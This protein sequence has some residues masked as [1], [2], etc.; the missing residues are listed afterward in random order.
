M[1]LKALEFANKVGTPAADDFDYQK[2]RLRS[3]FAANFT[4]TFRGFF[5]L[6]VNNVPDL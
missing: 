6:F 4:F 3:F 1:Y 2:A 5:N